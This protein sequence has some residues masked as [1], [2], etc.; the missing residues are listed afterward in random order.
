VIRACCEDLPY[1]I[2]FGLAAGHNPGGDNLAL[3]LGVH[4]ELDIEGGREPGR[5]RALEAAVG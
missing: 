3:P 4:V 2:G 1:P 5:L